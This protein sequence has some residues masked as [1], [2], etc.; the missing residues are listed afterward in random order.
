MCEGEEN[1]RQRPRVSTQLENL[2]NLK[3]SENL[4]KLEKPWKNQGIKKEFLEK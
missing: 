2:E 1:N 3:K 4:G